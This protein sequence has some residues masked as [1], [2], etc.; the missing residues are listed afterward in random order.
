MRASRSLWLFQER[1][2]SSGY[3]RHLVHN[4]TEEALHSLVLPSELASMIKYAFAAALALGAAHLG[5][6]YRRNKKY[7]WLV[8]H[9]HKNRVGRVDGCEA[10]GEYVGK[11]TRSIIIRCVA[12]QLGNFFAKSLLTHSPLPPTHPAQFDRLA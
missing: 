12:G 8:P 10:F 1:L 5:V 3:G 7:D 4:L 9:L 11:C 2:R 6:L